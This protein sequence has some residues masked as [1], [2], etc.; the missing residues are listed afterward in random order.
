M[1]PPKTRAQTPPSPAAATDRSTREVG[2]SSSS[3]RRSWVSG[4]VAYLFRRQLI[5]LVRIERIS[6]DGSASSMVGSTPLPR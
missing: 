4:I 1:R 5:D 2:A 6:A 3:A